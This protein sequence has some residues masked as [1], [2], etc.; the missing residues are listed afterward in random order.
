MGAV[1]FGEA[2][3]L[4]GKVGVV[5]GTSPCVAVVAGALALALVSVG[6]PGLSAA[7]L[8]LLIGFATSQRLLTGLGTLALLAAL[9]RFYYALSATLLVK[10]AILLATA[11]VLLA[12][13]A[14]L[15]H[16]GKE[17]DRA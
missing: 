1:F 11:A 2:L 17:A 14:V 16:A 5:R 15:H 6:V 10:S 9:A 13:S 8:I 12:C 7:L 4:V 3:W